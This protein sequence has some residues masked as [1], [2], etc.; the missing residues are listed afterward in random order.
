MADFWTF[1]PSEPISV[2]IEE[3]ANKMGLYLCYKVSPKNRYQVIADLVDHQ[4]VGEVN[5]F[6]HSERG[7]KQAQEYA[8][9]KLRERSERIKALTQK[10]GRT[11]F[12]R[13]RGRPG[14]IS[15]G[16][17]R[18]KTHNGLTKKQSQ[19]DSMLL[20]S[21]DEYR[22]LNPPFQFDSAIE[23]YPFIPSGSSLFVIEQGNIFRGQ[24]LSIREIQVRE[25]DVISKWA[26]F[27]AGSSRVCYDVVYNIEGESVRL[28]KHHPNYPSLVPVEGQDKLVF[29]E[30]S[31]ALKVRD[32]ILDSATHA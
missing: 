20:L 27:H 13:V 23:I 15:H 17:K 2:P 8:Y 1:N 6:M 25:F 28:D 11:L 32:E 9:T 24:G 30:K 4:S 31:E 19:I 10:S 5:V 16:H 26:D 3:F 12:S 21:F 22:E 7:L 29:M 18:K 14:R